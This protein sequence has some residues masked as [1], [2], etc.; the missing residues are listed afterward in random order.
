MVRCCQNAGSQSRISAST[1]MVVP[2]SSTV[3]SLLARTNTTPG[4][5]WR[6]CNGMRRVV[7]DWLLRK[8]KE[9]IPSR[10]PVGFPLGG[11]LSGL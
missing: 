2:Y 4:R 3:V 5:T 10:C 11:C 1:V 8:C 6:S 9:K 7:P